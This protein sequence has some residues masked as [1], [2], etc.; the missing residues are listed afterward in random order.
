[1]GDMFEVGVE[2]FRSEKGGVASGSYFV[3]LVIIY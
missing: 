2:V 3:P 1:M